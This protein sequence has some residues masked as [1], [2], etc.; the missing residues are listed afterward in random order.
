MRLRITARHIEVPPL[1][2]ELIQSKVDKLDKFGHKLLGLHV[3]LGRE[4]YFY[5]AELT[6]STKGLVL[7]GKARDRRDL[8]TCMEQAV[9]K[10]KEQLRRHESK[11]VEKRRRAARRLLV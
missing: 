11:M 9:M 8:L 1:L 3:I 10:L 7:V 5:T 4:K 6:L 2:Q